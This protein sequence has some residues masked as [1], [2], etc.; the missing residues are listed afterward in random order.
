[1]SLSFNS[2]LVQVERP[3]LDPRQT[4]GLRRIG[5]LPPVPRR[6]DWRHPGVVP[7]DSDY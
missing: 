5:G 7:K 2:R 3:P 6:T 1:M 4:A